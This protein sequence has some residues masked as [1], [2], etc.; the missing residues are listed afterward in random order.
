MKWWLWLWPARACSGTLQSYSLLMLV[1]QVYCKLCLMSNVDLCSFLGHCTVLWAQDEGLLG[2]L[3]R[4]TQLRAGSQSEAGTVAGSSGQIVDASPFLCKCMT[5]WYVRNYCLQKYC[6]RE[7]SIVQSR[8]KLHI[9]SFWKSGFLRQLSA[10]PPCRG[11][12][13]VARSNDIAE[14]YFCKCWR[15]L[16][17]LEIKS[18]RRE[19]TFTPDVL[20]HCKGIVSPGQ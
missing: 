10:P 19:V 15:R 7:K 5:L 13:C 2:I 18:P 16:S 20:L 12:A 4:T 9:N 17:C 1:V 14:I 8:T 6:K 11:A 3:F